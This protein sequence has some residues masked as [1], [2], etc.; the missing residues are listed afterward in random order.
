MIT[1]TKVGS[2]VKIDGIDGHDNV[3]ESIS[4]FQ[5]ARMSTDGTQLSLQIGE[6]NIGFKDLS[7]FTIGG[8]VP[9]NAATVQTALQAVFPSAAPA[10][11]LPTE[12][13]ATYSAM[14]TSITADP[15][16]KRDFFVSADEKNG[17]ESS[18]YK[19]DGTSAN[20]LPR[21]KDVNAWKYLIAAIGDSRLAN[22]LSSGIHWT[23]DGIL[24]WFM[25]YANQK[26]NLPASYNLAV[27]SYTTAQ[28]LGLVPSVLALNPKPRYCIVNGGTNSIAADVPITTIKSNFM[29]IADQLIAG[30]VIPV[31]LVDSPRALSTWGTTYSKTHQ[32]LNH[33]LRRWC[34]D[35]GYALVDPYNQLISQTTG[36]PLTG[37]TV[38]GI[39]QSARGASIIGKELASVFDAIAPAPRWS[40]RMESINDVFDA[41]YNPTGNLLSIGLLQGTAGSNNGTGASGSVSTGWQNRV[42]SGTATSVASKENP[43][44]DGLMGDKQILTVSASAT[45]LIRF[46][47]ESSIATGAGTYVTGDK[48]IGEVDIEVQ[49][50]SASLNYVNLTLFEI[51]G[52]SATLGQ[53]VAFK[54]ATVAAHPLPSTAFTGRLRTVP[55]IS[56]SGTASLLFRIEMEVASGG[57]AVVKIGNA[58]IRKVLSGDNTIL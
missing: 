41:T 7:Q 45:A 29:A 55:F 50:G 10:T 37:Y 24:T 44:S 56:Q 38:D 23:H 36:D 30:G 25:F 16:T 57:S 28:I 12:T 39:H 49:S 31:F 26:Y 15:L 40:S 46:S 48:L 51:N 58:T 18:I 33:W 43:R 5:G 20:R 42:V 52:S 2:L 34:R 35:N 53:S 14:Q 22:S 54:G 27:S 11:A 8:T 17:S 4:N 6:V 21:Q 47:P 19:Y 32:Q 1:I 9:T 3:Y 13:V